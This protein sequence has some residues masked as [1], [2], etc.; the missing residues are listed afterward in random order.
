MLNINLI[1]NC[2]I[3]SKIILE[4]SIFYIGYQNRVHGH[5]GTRN[6]AYPENTKTWVTRILFVNFRFFLRFFGFLNP[7]V[8]GY[9][10][11]IFTSRQFSDNTD[12]WTKKR[13]WNYNTFS[14]T[15][16]SNINKF[17]VSF[18]KLPVPK[19][20]LKKNLPCIPIYYK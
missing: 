18:L 15:I 12:V 10:K 13:D 8:P 16:V 14:G 5:P 1:L 11:K 17:F 20:L 9:P 3:Y 2:I 6:P 7:R 19:N 4:T